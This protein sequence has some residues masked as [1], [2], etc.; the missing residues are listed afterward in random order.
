M[1][2][3]RLIV[4][5]FFGISSIC[6]ANPPIECNA[7]K[8]DFRKIQSLTCKISAS[9]SS[10]LANHID[11]DCGREISVETDMC[12][13]H[14]GSYSNMNAALTDFISAAKDAG[15]NIIQADSMNVF[16]SK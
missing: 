2:F 4:L 3:I 15:F 16:L 5:T 7:Q 14:S 8:F 6:Y 1:G 11:I 10:W 13:G 12:D 9:D